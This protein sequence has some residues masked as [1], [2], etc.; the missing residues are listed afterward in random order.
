MIAR[1]GGHN[2]PLKVTCY[3][4]IIE[5]SDDKSAWTQ[6]MYSPLHNNC[7]NYWAVRVEDKSQDDHAR[8]LNSMIKR[9]NLLDQM[10]EKEQSKDNLKKI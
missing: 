3:R 7:R 2:C 9:L 8:M 4:F 10:K 1:C 5:S 6:S